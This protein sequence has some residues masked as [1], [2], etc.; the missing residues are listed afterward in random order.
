MIIKKITTIASVAA[1]AVSATTLGAIKANA[2]PY[3]RALLASGASELEA[4]ALSRPRT[5]GAPIT[6]RTLEIRQ[7]NIKTI[8]ENG[9][10]LDYLA[11][12]EIARAANLPIPSAYNFIALPVEHPRVGAVYDAVFN[13]PTDI[14]DDPGKSRGYVN[15]LL[16]GGVAE[17]DIDLALVQEYDA[18]DDANGE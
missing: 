17:D 5:S 3:E 2:S 6:R 4:V 10:G 8:K 16:T 9:T 7:D 11:E 14:I 18:A 1:L 15:A 13:D 12:V